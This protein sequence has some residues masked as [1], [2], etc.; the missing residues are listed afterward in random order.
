MSA[1]CGS[2]FGSS[3]H[4][5]A[6]WSLQ[7]PSSACQGIT[8][9]RLPGQLW[10]CL[11]G[12]RGC[13]THRT[14]PSPQASL[15]LGVPSARPSFERMWAAQIAQHP[16][17]LR[18]N[19][20]GSGPLCIG[21]A[22]SPVAPGPVDPPRI[23]CPGLADPAGGSRPGPASQVTAALGLSIPHGSQTGSHRPLQGLAPIK[24][25]KCKGR[26]PGYS[27]EVGILS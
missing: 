18:R 10:E 20:Q 23:E 24:R 12:S 4:Y 14:S 7:I 19:P 17:C 21:L 22:S 25:F 13:C 15:L 6:F 9:S 1:C 5:V 3:K 16:G 2:C 8:H 26:K 27:M 11:L